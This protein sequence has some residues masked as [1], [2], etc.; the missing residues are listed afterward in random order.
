MRALPFVVALVAVT[1][2]QGAQARAHRIQS[3]IA[4]AMQD[5]ELKK[6]LGS[7][8]AFYFSGQA[9]PAVA[10]TFGEF[11]TNKKTNSVGRPDIVACRWAMLSALLQLRERAKELGADAVVDIVSYYKKTRMRARP[12]TCATQGSVIAGVALKGTFV[13]VVGSVGCSNQALGAEPET[14]KT[15]GFH[16]RPWRHR[17]PHE[18]PAPG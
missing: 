16:R 9:K 15:A 13:K 3:A 17:R 1:G 12:I 11:V 8:V 5:A 14:G 10:K 4:E 6:N 7:D 2:V 18:E